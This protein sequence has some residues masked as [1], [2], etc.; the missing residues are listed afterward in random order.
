M[1]TVHC[2]MPDGSILSIISNLSPTS[3]SSTSNPSES[4]VGFTLKTH[5]S[6]ITSVQFFKH[7]TPLRYH[8][9]HGLEKLTHNWPPCIYSCC[10]SFF[11]TQSLESSLKPDI[12]L[13]SFPCN[14]LPLLFI[15]S[16]TTAQLLTMGSPDL[17]NRASAALQPY[18]R[19]APPHLLCFSRTGLPEVFTTL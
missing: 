5:L 3:T 9:L 13:C 14:T 11:S 1:K 7:H 16:G 6:P 15:T 18:L 19:F 10:T 2:T 8:L 12:R 17:H 4:S